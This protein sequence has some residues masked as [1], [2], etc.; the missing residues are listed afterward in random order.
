MSMLHPYKI[1]IHR[2][3]MKQ[4]LSGNKYVLTNTL[5]YIIKA[6]SVSLIFFK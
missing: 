1:M 4:T 2:V 3:K 6:K 5:L